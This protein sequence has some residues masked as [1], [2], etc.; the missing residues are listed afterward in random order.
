MV[1]DQN[2]EETGEEAC[3]QRGEQWKGREEW[4]EYCGEW[5]FLSYG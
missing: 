4:E 3:G 2:T 5:S 1:R